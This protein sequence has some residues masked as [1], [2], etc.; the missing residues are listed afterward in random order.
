[1][2]S[3]GERGLLGLAFHPRYETNGKFYVY[4]TLKGSNAQVVNEY[5]ASPPS[6]NT[7]DWHTGRRLLTMSDPYS[8]HNGGHMAFGPQEYLYIG[9][10]DGGSAGDPGNRAQSL[11]SLLGKM[12]RIDVSGTAGDKQYRI[13]PTNPYAGAVAGLDEIWARGLRNPWGFSFDRTQKDLWI[14]DVGQNLYEEV[15]VS[16]ASSG[17]GRA[18]NY[19]W[20]VMEGRHCFSPSTGCNTSGKVLPIVEYGHSSGNCSVTGGYVYRG[21]NPALAGGYFFGDFCSGRLWSIS[22]EASYPA[23]KVQHLQS[24]YSISGFGEDEAGEVYILFHEGLAYRITGT[25]KP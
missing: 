6:A 3:D 8:N 9:T 24:S 23:T 13:P 7:V 11:N 4:F 20:K 15:D 19:G 21:V 5:R 10:G 25:P 18:A 1:V 14:G 16:R 12:L 2:A 22:A 17:G